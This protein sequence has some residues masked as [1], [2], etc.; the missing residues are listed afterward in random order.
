VLVEHDHQQ[1]TRPLRALG[2]R[3]VDAGDERL[4]QREIVGRVPVVGLEV[5]VDD[6][7][8]G[9]LAA[10]GV[11]I[12]VVQRLRDDRVLAREAVRRVASEY[13]GRTLE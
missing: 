9:E 12:E 10:R 5:G 6:R 8:V 1:R 3:A 4:A 2:Q 11:A 7:Q 13:Q